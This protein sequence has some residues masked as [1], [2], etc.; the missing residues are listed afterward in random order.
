M[1][2]ELFQA[3]VVVLFLVDGPDS[4]RAQ[5][6]E[7]V[8]VI[9]E[10]KL[11]RGDIQ[12]RLPG[13]KDLEKPAVLQSLY[14]GTQIQASKDASAV[15]LFTDGS[16]TTTVNE[17][18]SPFEVKLP[19][20]KGSSAASGVGLVANFLLGKKKPPDY[21]P[22]AV[23][24]GQ[25]PPTLISPRNTKLLTDSPTFQ[26]MGMDRQTG[27][28]R[29]YSPEGLL[30]EA[31]DIA[32][33][34]I[35]YPPSAPRLKPGVE[36]SWEIE[37]KGFPA[38]KAQFKILTA[39]EAKPIQRQVSS[40][41]KL[42]AITKTTSDI[43]KGGL[44]ISHDLFYDARETLTKTVNADPDEPTLHFLLGEIYEKTGLTELAQE[45]YGEAA[46]LLQKNP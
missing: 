19:K 18:N 40:L 37:K 39:E 20:M 24:G 26:W 11:S 27:T 5:S 17:K 35:K 14:P 23:R 42:S 2:K 44:F 6:Q 3:L 16:G 28:V 33:T 31:E 13:K 46:F 30:W 45:E 36:Y 9:T 10:L 43:L 34:Q 15:V 41:N 38:E 29:V 1:K 4:L 8:A 21:V 12:I 32:L 7:A 22:L 25:H